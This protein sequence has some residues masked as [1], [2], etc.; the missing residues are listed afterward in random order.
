MNTYTCPER[1]KEGRLGMKAE[2]CAV[3]P[4]IE[5]TLED[6][7]RGQAELFAVAKATQKDLAELSRSVTEY[8]S[9]HDGI[10]KA[11]A[12]SRKGINWNRIAEHIIQ[13]GA[14]TIVSI[15]LVLA[16]IHASRLLSLFKIGG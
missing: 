10:E 9:Y 16:A 6:L 11:L 14:I 5:S 12:D 4:M 2:V 7:R 15:I 3:H 8:Q 13:W 1:R